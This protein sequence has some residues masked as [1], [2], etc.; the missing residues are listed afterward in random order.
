[1]IKN[2]KHGEKIILFS[3]FAD[4]VN[5][6]EK[7]LPDSLKETIGNFKELS[8]FIT[9]SSNNTEN[10]VGRFS[11]KSKNYNPV[12]LLSLRQKRS[13]IAFMRMITMNTMQPKPKCRK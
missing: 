11:P 8:G 1:M 6:L 7:V 5:Y 10:I 12:A 2:K 4:T 13:W 3:F 9:G